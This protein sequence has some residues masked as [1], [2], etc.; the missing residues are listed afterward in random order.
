M[1]GFG[2]FHSTRGE[3]ILTLP[4][5]P[6]E[7]AGAWQSDMDRAVPA[8]SVNLDRVS[9]PAELVSE[10]GRTARHMV[11]QLTLS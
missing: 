9:I 3:R 10:P 4:K 11:A 7:S 8:Y 6:L 2:W 5:W 1:V